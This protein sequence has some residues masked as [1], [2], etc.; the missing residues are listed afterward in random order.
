ML[1]LDNNAVDPS[2]IKNGTM[3]KLS[4][5]SSGQHVVQLNFNPKVR[6]YKGI[7][8]QKVYCK[9]FKKSI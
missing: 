9:I 2:T 7:M 5:P 6:I 8:F 4:I 1:K 3:Y